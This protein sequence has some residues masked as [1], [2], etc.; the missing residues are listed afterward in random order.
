[1]NV[2]DPRDPQFE[3]LKDVSRLSWLV[4]FEAVATVAGRD[5]EIPEECQ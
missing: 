4:N 3:A 1:M 5:T 2:H